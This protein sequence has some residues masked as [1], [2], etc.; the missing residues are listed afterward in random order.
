M[1]RG[2]IALTVS[3]VLAGP[4][5]VPAAATAGRAHG[6]TSGGHVTAGAR[7]SGLHHGGIHH[8]GG[9]H[10]FGGIHHVAPRPHPGGPHHFT[11]RPFA[12]RVLPFGVIAAPV[13]YVPSPLLYGPPISYDSASYDPSAA[14]GPPASYGPPM[15][16]TISVAP[17]PPPPTTPNVIEYPTG[18]YELRGDGLTTPYAWIWIPNPPPPP[19]TAPPPDGSGSDAPAPSR[20]RQ[21]YHW[22]DAEGVAHWTDI[23]D[24]VPAAYRERTDTR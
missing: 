8:V 19:P 15:G 22:T 2:L 14:Y 10:H 16:G 20:H 21:L 13:I 18:R 9:I 12:R 23:R 4:A 7:P 24:A 6:R 17:S 3:L 5:L 11:S 1:K